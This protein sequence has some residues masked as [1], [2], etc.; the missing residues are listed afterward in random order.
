MS[1]LI[2]ITCQPAELIL[3]LICMKLSSW[4]RLRLLTA[5]GGFTVVLTIIPL[6]SRQDGN[7][8]GVDGWVLCSRAVLVQCSAAQH[9]AA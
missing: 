7:T 1:R 5:Y 6:V 3:L 4:T 2:T 8:V 9:S